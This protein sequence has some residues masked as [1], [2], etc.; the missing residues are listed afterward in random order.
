MDLMTLPG[1]FRPISDSQ[2][3]ADAVGEER[4]PP[5]GTSLDL[6]TGSGIVAVAS[7]LAGFRASAVDVSRRA[8]VTTWL[9][10]RCNGGRVQVRRGHLFDPVGP[11]RFDLITGNPP[12]VPAP[13]DEL[14]TRG[15]SRAWVA[16][17]DG[18]ALID[19]ICD[20]AVDRLTPGG[21]ILLVHSSLCD[22]DATVERLRRAGLDGAAVVRGHRGPLGPLMREQ[23]ELGTIPADI[24]QEE[25][26]IIRAQAPA[27]RS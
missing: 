13:T 3:L 8:L 16:G 12:Y 25:V 27:L 24:D 4:V 19:E 23:Q 1:V 22:D 15:A 14:P 17:R 20:R 6:C 21:A 7:S 2:M 10:A 26:V 9:N 5:G 11:Q 18:R